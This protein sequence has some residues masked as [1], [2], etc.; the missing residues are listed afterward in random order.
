MPLESLEQIDQKYLDLVEKIN[1]EINVKNYS[2]AINYCDSILNTVPNFAIFWY[3]KAIA[4]F[5]S[6]TIENSRFLESKILFEKAL[7]LLSDSKDSQFIGLKINELS[8]KYLD[9]FESYFKK[10]YLELSCI[11]IY[12]SAYEEFDTVINWAV[13]ISPD[14]KNLLVLGYNMCRKIT[15]IPIKYFSLIDEIKWKGIGTQLASKLTKD[16]SQAAQGKNDQDIAT[17]IKNKIKTKVN[18]LKIFAKKYEKDLPG[19]SELKHLLKHNQLVEKKPKISSEG[20]TFD[21]WVESENKK[22]KIGLLIG[23]AIG[24][25][26]LYNYYDNYWY[27]TTW[28][29]IW[30][31]LGFLFLLMPIWNKP[32]DKKYIKQQGELSQ[33]LTDS[34][35]YLR[36]TKLSITQLNELK[37]K[38]SLI[39]ESYFYFNSGKIIDPSKIVND[40]G[41]LF[42]NNS[43]PYK[44]SND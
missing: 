7:S 16:S 27:L 24:L 33:W 41:S 10:N 15:Q 38:S 30:F 23:L 22:N 2:K 29:F 19:L 31:G 6:S 28:T 8:V 20:K 37:S 4:V 44:L 42:F 18:G 5:N 39:Y 1:D 9:Q 25:V 3:L 11:D 35:N 26:G 32:T 34:H 40:L 36:K 21:E 12:S 14:N 13:Q 43:A 17:E